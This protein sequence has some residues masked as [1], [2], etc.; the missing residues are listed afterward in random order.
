MK[1][2]KSENEL[3]LMFEGIECQRS[4]YLFG[5]S[6]LI[7]IYALRIYKWKVFDNFIMFLIACSSVKLALATYE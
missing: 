5:K 6:N 1:K 4:V 7:R 2:E 3:Q